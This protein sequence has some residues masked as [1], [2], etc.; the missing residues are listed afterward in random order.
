MVGKKIR[1][2]PGKEIT[3]KK[4]IKLLPKPKSG[5]LNPPTEKKPETDSRGKELSGDEQ[6]VTL[7]GIEGGRVRARLPNDVEVEAQE[8]E[9]LPGC[10]LKISIERV[11]FVPDEEN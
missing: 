2:K 6:K 11:T 10:G 3:E 8:G 9:E 4:I 7:L 1:R 5:I